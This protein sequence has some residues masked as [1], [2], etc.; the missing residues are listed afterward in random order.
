[1]KTQPNVVLSVPSLEQQKIIMR[2]VERWQQEKA[3]RLQVKKDQ[4]FQQKFNRVDER[5]R[6]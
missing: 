2:N 4:Q 5:A 3:H 1:M 6:L